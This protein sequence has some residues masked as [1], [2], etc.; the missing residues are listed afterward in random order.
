MSEYN[1]LS[2]G[3][4]RVTSDAFD[5]GKRADAFLAEKIEERIENL[6]ELIRL[7]EE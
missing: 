2:D 4:L 7:Y 1:E 5:K 3:V 6:G